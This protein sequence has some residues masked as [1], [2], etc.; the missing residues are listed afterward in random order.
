[1]G[2][3]F[4]YF[5]LLYH[6][7]T[8]LPILKYYPVI[9]RWKRR[10]WVANYHRQS[11]Q[12][13]V[14]VYECCLIQI[15]RAEWCLRVLEFLQFLL[16]HCLDQRP[17][18]LYL[19]LWNTQRKHKILLFKEMTIIKIILLFLSCMR[20]YFC[21]SHSLTRLERYSTNCSRNLARFSSSSFEARVMRTRSL[22]SNWA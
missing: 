5:F 6:K 16:L 15:T 20:R 18:Y 8:L 4:Q 3:I 10:C 2:S 9:R 12:K 21:S 22:L 14:P 7:N 19:H 13:S 17:T 11:W 1:M